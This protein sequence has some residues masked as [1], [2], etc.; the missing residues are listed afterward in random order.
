M[1]LNAE[2]SAG[3]PMLSCETPTPTWEIAVNESFAFDVHAHLLQ[4]EPVVAWSVREEAQVL[5]T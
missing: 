2:N 3:F 5:A 1:M 4:L